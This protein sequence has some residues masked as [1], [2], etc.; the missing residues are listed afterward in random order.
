MKTIGITGNIGCGKSAVAAFISLI[1][2]LKG[3]NTQYVIG[4]IDAD[5]VAK[6][7]LDENKK[8]SLKYINNDLDDVVTKNK[9]FNEVYGNPKEI[10]KIRKF[11]RWIH[12]LVAERI[13]LMVKE[14]EKKEEKY[15]LINAPLLFEARIPTD[16]LILVTC[17]DYV[18]WQR[19][20]ARSIQRGIP[21][22]RTKILAEMQFPQKLMKYYCDFQIEN[23]EDFIN[24]TV[25]QIINVVNEIIGDNNE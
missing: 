14:A 7:I 20:A 12:K 5:K 25:P 19:V 11:N 17:V 9:V 16:Y 3:P 15:L 10:E 13:N 2:D 22:G 24:D 18:R 23:S 1:K 21:A 6:E 4:C 8:L